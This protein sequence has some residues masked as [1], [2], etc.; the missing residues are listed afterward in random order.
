[1]ISS[2]K[3]LQALLAGIV[4]LIAATCAGQA[5]AQA[6]TQLAPTGGPPIARFVH[7]AVFNTVSNRMIVFGGIDGGS[8]CYAGQCL[9]DVWVLT[10][11]D[12]SGGPSIWTQLSPIGGPPSARG[13]HA[14]VYDA[15]NNRMVV[16]A[17][18]PSIGFCNFAVNDVWV[19]TNADGTG[20]TP[21]W[22]QLSP[23]GGPPWTGQGSG[24]AYD[25]A[26][27]S[28]IVFGGNT[29]CNAYSNAVWVL[30]N[31]NGLG[32][33]PV[34]TQQ[35][36]TGAAPAPRFVHSAV[37][38]GANHRMIVFGGENSLG[39]LNDV[40]V[41]TNA[42]GVGTPVWTQLS[43][44]GAPAPVRYLHTAV[45]DPAT[46][47]MVVF[48]GYNG[49]Y[50]NDTWVLSN[51]DGTGGT[52]AWTQLSPTGTPPAARGAHS[53]IYNAANNRM[54]VF[55][56]YFSTGAL[57]NDVWVLTSASGIIDIPVAIDIKAGVTPNTI[58]LA[59]DRD[60]TVAILSSSTFNAPTAV[61]RK[62]LTFGHT[63]TEASLTSCNT[64]S[65]DVNGDNRMDLVCH[66]SVAATGFQ[67]GDTLG[68]LK[69]LTLVGNA[70]HGSDTVVVH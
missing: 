36:P 39:L 9:N 62:S 41:L 40:W 8:G 55:G 32:G 24:A 27:N 35:I 7:S 13:L 60:I 37:Y 20:G 56:G 48:G 65:R 61:D 57:T 2:N 33:T 51:A 58:N 3:P 66:F 28:M 30:T 70:I 49:S 15:T 1:M 21:V 34:W 53:A 69:G 26:T 5:A 38:N 46:N 25:S 12:G 47:R 23:T 50:A 14:A 59:L 64:A 4:F 54:V 43:P 44:T 63:G 19:L 29:N 67:L 52:P 45:Y 18:N 16:F 10:N 42:N 22:S 68:Y 11:A 17:G 31:A 6:W